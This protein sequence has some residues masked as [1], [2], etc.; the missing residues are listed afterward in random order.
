MPM[1]AALYPLQQLKLK[2]A[3]LSSI[4]Q[5]HYLARQ[6]GKHLDMAMDLISST[7]QLAQ[8]KVKEPGATK[9]QWLNQSRQF[10]NQIALIS[11]SRYGTKS[12]LEDES[13]VDVYLVK[14]KDELLAAI[15]QGKKIRIQ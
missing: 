9:I 4:P 2:I 10:Q 14:L 11:A 8:N 13:D 3:G 15:K 7:Y 12:Y 5:I 1:P 6:V